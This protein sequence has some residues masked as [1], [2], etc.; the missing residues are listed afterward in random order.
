MGNMDRGSKKAIKNTKYPMK[1]FFRTSIIF[2]SALITAVSC[3]DSDNVKE[4]FLAE[5]SFNQWMESNINTNGATRAVKQP[6]GM[7]IEW[8]NEAPSTNIKP[9]TGDWLMINYKGMA[10]K[11]FTYDPNDPV[12]AKGN[13]FMTRSIE[14]AR[15][16]AKYASDTSYTHYVPQYV[17]YSNTNYLM[18]GQQAALNQMRKGDKV[19]LYL[20]YELAYDGF[21]LTASNGYGGQIQQ[22]SSPV[23]VEMELTDVIE[24]PVARE[25]KIVKDY[26]MN[27]WGLAESDTIRRNLYLEVTDHIIGSDTLTADSVATLY[28]TGK[29]AEDDF[30]FQTNVD[31]VAKKAKRIS[32]QNDSRYSSYTSYFS[33]FKGTHGYMDD[34]FSEAMKSGKITYGC[35]FRMVFTS[36]YGDG[37]SY[38]GFSTRGEP[39]TVI[40]SHTPLVYEVY[41]AP[42]E[43]DD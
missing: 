16:F 26:A 19:R 12:N 1:L 38:I 8:L 4:E 35:S 32:F 27:R 37:N 42:K 10:L 36:D 39:Y 40:Q 14:D 31:T 7:Y 6:N 23:I 22:P 25:E 28:F 2:I 41:V 33:T 21:S 9:T 5:R 13:I 29:F 30:I 17:V 3:A 15:R 24:D 18:S 34:A 11:G 20:P 43:E